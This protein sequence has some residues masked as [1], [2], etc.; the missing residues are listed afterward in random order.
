MPKRTQAQLERLEQENAGIYDKQEVDKMLEDAKLFHKPERLQCIIALASIFGKRLGEIV[1][2]GVDDIGVK[3]KVLTVMFLLEKKRW[4]EGQPRPYV[5]KKITID[6]PYAHY[7]IDYVKQTKHDGIKCTECGSVTVLKRKVWN[8]K[9]KQTETKNLSTK[10]IN[11]LITKFPNN[12]KFTCAKCNSKL[13]PVNVWLFPSHSK[14]HTEVV[15]MHFKE[16]KTIYKDSEGKPKEIVSLKY[17]KNGMA[18]KTY[19]Y[20]R[21]G[22][23]LSVNGAEFIMRK[24]NPN[25][26]WHLFRETV[27]V[28]MLEHNYTDVQGAKWLDLSDT[29]IFMKHYGKTTDKMMRK[30]TLRKW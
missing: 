4:Q 20:H 19:R 14:D 6:H 28:Q 23:H 26:W 10:E 8:P 29:K 27:A 7:I 3:G 22:G 1:Q 2:L 17:D 30:A 21:S 24:L 9:L 25:G 13:S 16:I 15:K 18:E 12:P 5:Y 11:N